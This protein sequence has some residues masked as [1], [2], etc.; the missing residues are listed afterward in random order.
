MDTL[1][2]ESEIAIQWF[3][4][5]FMEAN[6]DKFQCMILG[7]NSV[8]SIKIKIQKYNATQVSNYWVLQL[9]RI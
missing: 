9:T 5:N 6:P 7:D 8:K 1:K 3:A 2:C 4:N